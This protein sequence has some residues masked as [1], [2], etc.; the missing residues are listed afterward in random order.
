MNYSFLDYLN[1]TVT[2]INLFILLQANYY[3]ADILPFL[4][5]HKV[6]YFTH[7][8]SR[9]ANNGLSGSIQ[10]LRCRANYRALKY[11]APIEE[12]GATLISR[13]HEG[14]SPYL[15]LH[16]RQVLIQ[17]CALCN[18]LC[19]NPLVLIL[20]PCCSPF[21]PC[22]S[23]V[24]A[25]VLPIVWLNTLDQKVVLLM[26]FV[27]NAF[28]AQI[29]LLSSKFIHNYKFTTLQNYLTS[30]FLPQVNLSTSTPPTSPKK[31]IYNTQPV[32]IS[33]F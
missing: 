10:K 20:S 24:Q 23:A 26:Q 33:S 28:I 5:Q 9:L 3:K 11:S 30:H 21:K 4:K 18:F 19:L 15:A 7:T 6:I 31:N 16:L 12:L 17:F 25:F 22:F 14:G 32:Y 1:W 2:L 27:R 8:D 29:S 13:M